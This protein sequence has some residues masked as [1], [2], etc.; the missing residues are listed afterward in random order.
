MEWAVSAVV[1]VI[2]NFVNHLKKQ[3]SLSILEIN[4]TVAP[5]KVAEPE[6]CISGSE[7][8][9]MNFKEEWLETHPT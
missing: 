4:A 5:S 1:N 9:F 2:S 8:A 7:S 3:L 6:A